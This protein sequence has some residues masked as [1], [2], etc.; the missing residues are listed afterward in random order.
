MIFLIA[1]PCARYNNVMGF[2]LRYYCIAVWPWGGYLNSLPRSCHLWDSI[3]IVP[4]LLE[5]LG[6]LSK[7]IQVKK[8]AQGLAQ[9]AHRKMLAAA[10]WLIAVKLLK[11]LVKKWMHSVSLGTFILTDMEFLWFPMW[12]ILTQCSLPIVHIKWVRNPGG[13]L[14]ARICILMKSHKFGNLWFRERR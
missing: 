9:M 14:E 12:I 8:L 13:R 6:G 5:L 2:G 10:K 7:I 11:I 4:A 3:I 1:E